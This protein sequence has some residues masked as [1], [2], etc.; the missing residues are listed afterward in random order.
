LVSN[1][2]AQGGRWEEVAQIRAMTKNTECIS[3]PGY[4]ACLD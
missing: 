1:I 3:T 2:C 4:S